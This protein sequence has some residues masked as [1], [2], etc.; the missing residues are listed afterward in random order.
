M[1]RGWIAEL[2]KEEGIC[3]MRWGMIADHEGRE[4][5]HGGGREKPGLESRVSA[6]FVCRRRCPPLISL[7]LPPS[8]LRDVYLPYGTFCRAP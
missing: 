3:E 6:L 4:T 8:S 7:V 1:S 5:R 2:E